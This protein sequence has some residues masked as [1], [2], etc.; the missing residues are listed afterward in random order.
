MKKIRQKIRKKEAKNTSSGAITNQTIAEH[1]EKILAGG[2]RFKYP[3]QYVRHKLVINA[4]LIS[5]VAVVGLTVLGWWQLYKE[6]NT[7]EFMYRVTS[8]VPVPVASVDGYNVRYSDYLLRYRASEK[9]LRDDARVNLSGQDGKRQL[10]FMKRSVLDL[11]ER[12][13]FA[14]KI[15]K[16]K[17]IRI[18]DKEVQDVVDGHRKTANGVVSQEVYDISTQDTLGLSYDEYRQLIKQS[19]VS[20]AAAYA[21]DDEANRL[22]ESIA[23]HLAKNKRQSLREATSALQKVSASIQYG[24]SG[25]VPLNNQDRGLPQLASTLKQGQVSNVFKSSNG[26]GYYFVRLIKKT[27]RTIEYEFI[28]APLREFEQRFNRLKSDG[29]VS[30]Y[31]NIPDAKLENFEVK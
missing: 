8:F 1:R 15:A 24:V 13:S 18:S 27:N 10:D 5:V 7:S 11:V 22:Q 6:Q 3:H 23:A 21:I 17:N 19:L 12:N 9:Y 2:R 30:E 26:D 16:E 31:I 20:R 29:K 4:I 25:E 28:S 14:E